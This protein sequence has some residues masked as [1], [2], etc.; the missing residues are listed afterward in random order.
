MQGCGCAV[1]RRRGGAAARW[2]GGAAVRRGGTIAPIE[3]IASRLKMTP[4]TAQ[5]PAL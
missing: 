5:Y 3:A 2:C 4:K 1:V